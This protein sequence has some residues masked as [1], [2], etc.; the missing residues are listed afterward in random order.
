MQRSANITHNCT[1]LLSTQDDVYPSDEEGDGKEC[2]LQVCEGL[3][4]TNGYAV[5]DTSMRVPA[6]PYALTRWE[7]PGRCGND[8]EDTDSL[9]MSTDGDEET[10]DWSFQESLQV[11]I[12]PP[13]PKSRAL[14]LLQACLYPEC[15]GTQSFGN[16][17]EFGKWFCTDCLV[18]WDEW[19]EWDGW[20]YISV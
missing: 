3:C 19:D 9:S 4:G 17:Y 15:G 7:Q 16:S 10:L 2:R 6:N 12:N 8:N 11:V 18:T 13:R 1:M 5:R 20:D 14:A